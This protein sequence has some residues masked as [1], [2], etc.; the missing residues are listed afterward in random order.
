MKARKFMKIGKLS[1]RLE[2][3]LAA[4]GVNV[5]I[6]NFSD[7]G[8]EATIYDVKVKKGTRVSKI[9]ERLPD[10][11]AALGI[12]ILHPFKESNK[13]YI[14]ASKQAE[15]K[16][17]LESILKSKKYHEAKLRMELPLALGYKPWRSMKIVDLAKLFGLLVASAPGYGK[18]V[19]LQCL[20]ISL[21]FARAVSELNLIIFDIGAFT[22]EMFDK[23]PHLSCPIVKDV[24]TAIIVMEL[25]A[26]EVNR[27]LELNP[28]ER[29]NE[30]FLVIVFDE[31]VSTITD[32][33]NNKQQNR[34]IEAASSVFRKG[35][36][37]KIYPV[38]ATQDSTK[39]NNKVDISCITARIALR[40]ATVHDS[41]TAIGCKGAEK[42]TKPG[43][44]LF[45]SPESIDPE[46]LQGAFMESEHITELV[47]AISERP[48]NNISKSPNKFVIT[49]EQISQQ[50]QTS[51]RGKFRDKKEVADIILWAIGQ[52]NISTRKIQKQFRIGNRAADIMDTLRE[53]GIVEDKF[54]NLPRA[55]TVESQEDIPENVITFLSQN[56]VTS[57]DISKAMTNHND[58]FFSAYTE[59]E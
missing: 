57:E 20:I 44:M 41:I 5:E 38:L 21:I 43:E 51:L 53:M 10:I 26:D 1:E 22:L 8:D 18:T 58:D 12:E 40:S 6:S 33:K 29:E 50:I 32:I 36:K 23:L 24:E 31:F 15:A 39:K 30:P 13:I 56:G 2:K 4:H 35:R 42:L 46:Y 45:K 49:E 19:A 25:V 17:K 7:V 28:I 47:K 37:V 14:F 48:T 54:A 27:R 16:N 34:F 59:Q 55:I 9:F 3:H 52:K 11:K